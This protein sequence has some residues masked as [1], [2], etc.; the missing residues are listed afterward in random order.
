MFSKKFNPDVV[1]IFNDNLNN[2][3]NKNFELKNTP[4]KLIIMDNKQNIN[5]SKDLIINTNSNNKNILDD[6]NIILDERKIKN[7]KNKNNSD[8]KNELEL[9]D[10]TMEE[11]ED[12]IDDFIDIKQNFESEFKETEIEIKNDRNKFNSILES[13]LSDGLLD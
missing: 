8:I 4:Y 12:Y 11:E 7:K 1:N 5:T 9:S 3:K 10:I 6:Y 2:R 13:L